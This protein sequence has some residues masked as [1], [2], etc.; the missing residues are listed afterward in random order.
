MTL[1]FMSIFLLTNAYARNRSKEIVVNL[2]TNLLFEYV[3]LSVVGL[4][5]LG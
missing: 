1:C 3:G 4:G 5:T 2:A